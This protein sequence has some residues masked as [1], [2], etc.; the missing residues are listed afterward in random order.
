[1]KIL[2]KGRRT[3]KTTE[4][5]KVANETGA[6]LVVHSKEEAK[7]VSDDTDR[8][9]ITYSELLKGKMEGSF[10][11]NIVIDNLE[12]FL[13]RALPGVKIELITTTCE[14]IKG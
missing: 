13:Q 7:R 6:Y 2:R 8:F 12:V 5:I 3:G 10:V 9:P 14:E 4:A 1:M 11:R